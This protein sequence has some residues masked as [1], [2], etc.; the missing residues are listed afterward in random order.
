MNEFSD[1]V[2]PRLIS[3][4]TVW[5]I[6]EAVNQGEN[7]WWVIACFLLIS[8]VLEFLAFRHGVAQG[9]QIYKEATPKQRRDIDKILEGKGNK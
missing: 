2:L 9:I 3:L 4:V 6:A 1:R 8:L 7:H 5:L